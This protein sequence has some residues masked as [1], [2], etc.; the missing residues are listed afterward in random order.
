MKRYKTII[1]DWEAFREECQQHEA[2]KT[3]RKNP[4]KAGQNFEEKLREDFPDAEK[5]SWNPQVYRL[6]S[7]KTPGKS[8]LHWRGEYYVQEESASLP[9]EVLNPELGEKVLDMCAAPGGK[10]TQIAAEMEN[11]G[12]LI[13]N[14]D[15]RQRLKSLHANIYRTGS[16]AARVTNYDGRQIPKETKFDKILV[17]AP[18]SGE[19]NNARRSFNP[20]SESDLK[21]LPE[22]QQKLMEN[23]EKL[24]KDGGEVVYSSCTFVP[25]ENEAVVEKILDET[26]FELKNIETDA[27]HVRGVEEFQG[28]SF[29]FDT[30]KTVRIYPHHLK[31]GG[32]FVARFGK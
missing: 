6:N 25:E 27:E 24:L 11:S 3:V 32:I 30:S 4:L 23:A 15:N 21:S 8:P 18:C 22:I 26:A 10:T 19:G 12:L 28:R 7:E 2:R 29:E 14:D 13:A 5:S 16:A 31:S 17:D 9:V 1:D 20:A